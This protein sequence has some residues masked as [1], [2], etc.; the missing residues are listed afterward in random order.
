MP[1]RTRSSIRSRDS[2]KIVFTETDFSI[3]QILKQ[4]T[5]KSAKSKISTILSVYR[6]IPLQRKK[7]GTGILGGKMN[8]LKLIEV[9]LHHKGYKHV[10]IFTC[11][12]LTQNTI[13]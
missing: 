10:I 11:K 9:Q 6:E 12:L 3:H 2:L 5:N 1:N 4:N 8:R 7:N 13:K